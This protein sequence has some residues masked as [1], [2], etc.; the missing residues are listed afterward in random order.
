MTRE[1]LIE[2]AMRQYALRDD[3][4]QCVDCTLTFRNYYGR[5]D[6]EYLRRIIERDRHHAHD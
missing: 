5:K 2:E 1:E 4:C 6:D 3:L